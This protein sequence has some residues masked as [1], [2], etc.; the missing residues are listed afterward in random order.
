MQL[1]L[2]LSAADA[3]FINATGRHRTEY[4]GTLHGISGSEL[5]ETAIRDGYIRFKEGTRMSR[6]WPTIASQ[7]WPWHP[8]PCKLLSAGVLDR[9][10]F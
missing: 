1:V 10:D 4:I 7:A 2:A 3:K 8:P 5:S 6:N 9:H